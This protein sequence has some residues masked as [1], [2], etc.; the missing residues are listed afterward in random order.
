ML[1]KPSLK[2]GYIAVLHLD[3]ITYPCLDLDALFLNA[4]LNKPL[5]HIEWESVPLIFVHQRSYGSAD[6]ET[7][8]EYKSYLKRMS[9]C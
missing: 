6:R 3:V 5:Y 2:L 8:I 4:I 7:F 1:S 9:L